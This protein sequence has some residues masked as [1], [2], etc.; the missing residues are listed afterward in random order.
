MKQVHVVRVKYLAQEH[1]TRD[2]GQGP[3]GPT[4]K[5]RFRLYGACTLK[6]IMGRM[7][8][9]IT[10]AGTVFDVSLRDRKMPVYAI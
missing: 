1:N 6:G 10:P 3:T 8:M 2:A 7:D 5:N 4:K 9:A